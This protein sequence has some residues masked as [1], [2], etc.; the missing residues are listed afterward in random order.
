MSYKPE[1]LPFAKDALHGISEKTID[2]HYEKLYKGYVNKYN[3]IQEKL[4]VAN[5]DS[6]NQTYSEWRALKMGETF[7]EDGIILHEMY[8]GNLGGNG[9][10]TNTGIYKD[11]EEQFGSFEKFKAMVNATA[12]AARGWAIVAWNSLE[13]NIGIYAADSHNQGGIWSSMPFLVIDVYEHAYYMDYGSDRKSYLE[14]FWKNVDW[15]AVNDRY[16][17]STSI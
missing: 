5:T 4:Q 11:I 2:Y 6:A 13:G 16:Q 1:A 3:E 10:S 9:N 7:A 15:E 14:A 17:P 12:M 8:F